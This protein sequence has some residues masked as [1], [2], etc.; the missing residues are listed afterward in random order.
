MCIAIIKPKNVD[1]PSE[2]ILRI[3]F[4]NNPDGAGF[5]FNRN[6]KNYIHKGFFTF[7]S[8]WDAISSVNI[9][10]EESALIHFRVATHGNI[11]KYTC[12]PFLITNSYE[13]M[14]EPH[15]VTKNGDVMIHN[16]MLN[17]ELDNDDISDSMYLAKL[18]SNYDLSIDSNKYM[19][20]VALLNNNKSKMNR[21]G[22]LRINN[23]T[24]IYGFK[25]PW[26]NVNGCFFSNKSYMLSFS[27]LNY[28]YGNNTVTEYERKEKLEYD[29][30]EIQSKKV[31]FCSNH[32]I[33]DNPCNE[34][35]I[36]A[37]HYN[38]KDYDVYCENC[39]ND[40]EYFNC[41]Y[42]HHSFYTKYKSEANNIC[43]FCYN[44]NS[45]FIFHN[46]CYLCDA[47]ATHVL[48][49][50]NNDKNKKIHL[51]E[52]CFENEQPFLCSECG[53]WHSII[54][55]SNIENFCIDCY[56]KNKTEKSCV[57][58]HSTYDL[59]KTNYSIICHKCFSD[60]G[61]HFCHLCNKPYIYGGGEINGKHFCPSCMKSNYANQFILDNFKSYSML[62]E[63]VKDKLKKLFNKSDEKKKLDV[64]DFYIK[65]NF[66]DEMNKNA[67]VV[68]E[69]MKG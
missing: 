54:D 2:Y 5:A 52:Q 18:L 41:K 10:K 15:I 62:N 16:G 7:K 49:G 1:L 3:C 14:Q 34:I 53:H 69:M 22:I 21:V 61:G 6:G 56:E 68:C 33:K 26:E 44:E 45:E 35:G 19:F 29:E 59:M 31:D 51:C 48:Y 57:Y 40:V 25:E 11:D 23:T 28:N 42:C 30:N 20:N 67:N 64:I 39:I 8:F 65:N 32:N 24:E 9:K 4:N 36:Y 55:S 38:G 37:V 13:D 66:L 46:K 63:K 58:C 43:I 12:H 27:R 60:K 17:F 50:N 47:K